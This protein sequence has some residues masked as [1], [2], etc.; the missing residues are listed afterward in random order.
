VRHLRET[1]QFA[2]GLET[3][4]AEPE[5]ILLEVG[6][7]NTLGTF[8]RQRAGRSG[9]PTIVPSLRHPRENEADGAFLLGSLGKLWLAGARVAATGVFAGEERRRVELPTYPF[10]RERYWIDPDPRAAAAAASSKKDADE[11][12]YVPT[13]KS[14]LPRGTTEPGNGAAGPQR[15]LIFVDGAGFGLRLV[16]HLRERRWGGRRAPAR[17][18]PATPA[19]AS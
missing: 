6:P 15:W 4:A 14:G 16:E 9:P 11:W 8:A 13:W 12:F 18:S 10:E 1:V 17:P 3:L 7:G 5:H 2:R 19:P